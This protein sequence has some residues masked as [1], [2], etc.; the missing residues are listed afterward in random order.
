MPLTPQNS[1]IAATL[2][3]AQARDKG[4]GGLAS[5][6]GAADLGRDARAQIALRHRQIEPRLE[7][8]PEPRAVAE[9]AVAG[10]SRGP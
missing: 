2:P 1:K 4:V 8:Q 10:L 3:D 9:G 7:V 6:G 5:S